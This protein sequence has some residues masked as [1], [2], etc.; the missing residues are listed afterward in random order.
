VAA[1]A[2][3]ATCLSCIPGGR[4]VSQR[5]LRTYFRPA[6]VRENVEAPRTGA[7]S[8]RRIR[9]YADEDYRAQDSEW[10]PTIVAQIQRAS[11]ITEADFGVRLEI[12]SV[13]PWHRPLRSAPLDEA[14]EELYDIDAGHEVDWVVGY[15]SARA[16]ETGRAEIVGRAHM[17]GSH[18][19]LRAMESEA[20]R[21]AVT[22]WTELTD[23]ERAAMARDW[24][25]HRETTV[26][27]HEWAHTLGAVHECEDKWIMAPKHTL[28]QSAFSPRSARLAEIGLRHRAKDW[29]AAAGSRGWASEYEAVADSMLGASWECE[30]M[31]KGL[32]AARK[33][34]AA[35]A[36]RAPLDPAGQAR[37]E[38]RRYVRVV[39]REVTAA[40]CGAECEHR[41]SP[42]QM[43]GSAVVFIDPDGRVARLALTPPDPAYERKLARAFE[44]LWVPP[45]PAALQESCRTEGLEFLLR[46]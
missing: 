7:S 13:R 37:E 16:D 30:P 44:R 6:D 9:A 22:S 15:V 20:D 27:L 17:F 42:W 26:F 28:M 11:Q 31:E 5:E 39:L 43:A 36:R 23:L 45:P 34:L 35:A 18:F 19:V 33:A 41:T 29:D 3:V 14:L 10:Q 46:M 38:R 2:L 8:V 21:T 32:A 1:A 24:R 40:Y 4:V 12:D 25:L